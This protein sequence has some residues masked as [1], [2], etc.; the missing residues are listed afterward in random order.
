M[1]ANII[2][3]MFELTIIGQVLEIMSLVYE[4]MALTH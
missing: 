3:L 4:I 2:N 1:T